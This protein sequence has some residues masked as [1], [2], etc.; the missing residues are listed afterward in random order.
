MVTRRGDAGG[1]VLR[2]RSDDDVLE[3]L[4]GNDLLFGLLGEDFLDGGNGSDRLDGGGGRDQMVGGA[5]NDIYVT[6]DRDDRINERNNEGLDTLETTYSRSLPNNL[7]NLTL[8]GGRPI[9]GTGSSG[10][11]IL[12][13][14]S[15]N[16]Q[17]NGQNGSD[18]LDGEAG[19]DR[20]D[21]GKGSDF[22]IGGAGNDTYIVDINSDRI[23]EAAAQGIDT[24]VSNVS[25]TLGAYLENLS[26]VGARAVV[27]RGN[28][29]NN[30][31]IGNPLSNTLKGGAGVDDLTGAGGN[32]TLVGGKGFDLFLYKTGRNFR[33]VDIGTD[34]ITDFR[35][36]TDA[37]VLSQQTFGLSSNLGVGFSNL[38]EFQVVANNGAAAQSSARIVFSRATGTLFYNPNGTE[39]G[40]GS[41]E[42]SGAFAV[43]R[44]VRSLSQFD[45]IIEA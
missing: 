40:F 18:R 22:M 14:N 8:I 43:L 9:D 33:T 23:L 37:I 12:I 7:E 45:F 24:V 29:L 11:N 15:A 6:D 2:G 39:G 13:G 26:L 38:S 5:G 42:G 17:L 16:N 4:N 1:N 27:G 21:G 19:S 3:G 20:L 35:Q 28:N 34:S 32:D 31:L 30:E 41:P 44:G 25:Y 10:N 36:G